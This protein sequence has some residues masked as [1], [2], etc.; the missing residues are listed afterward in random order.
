MA[1]SAPATFSAA[2]ARLAGGTQDLPC[3]RRVR[4]DAWSEQTKTAPTEGT[5]ESWYRTAEHQDL[6]QRS[7]ELHSAQCASVSVT[8]CPYKGDQLSMS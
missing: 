3:W 2:G 8:R 7:P 5:F 1:N 6:N 4:R